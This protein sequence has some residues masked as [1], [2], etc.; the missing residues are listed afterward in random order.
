MRTNSQLVAMVSAV[1]IWSVCDVQVVGATAS[2]G[3]ATTP[4]WL[5][6]IIHLP[7]TES[8]QALWIGFRN[9]GK[10]PQGICLPV[11][12]DYSVSG[13]DGVDMGGS[14]WP[15]AGSPHSC[16]ADDG[17]HLVL[18]GETVFRLGLLPGARAGGP[19]SS[20][21]IAFTLQG[22][23]QELRAKTRH[24][25]AW[26]S[27]DAG[28]A[29]QV[30]AAGLVTGSLVPAGQWKASVIALF[31]GLRY[32]VG[33]RNDSTVPR[34]I[35]EPSVT[36]EKSSP[37]GKHLETWEVR[38]GA[39]ECPWGSEGEALLLLP[40][41]TSYSLVVL[42]IDVRRPFMVRVGAREINASQPYDESRVD[43]SVTVP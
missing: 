3:A 8:G 19:G 42:P 18:P 35:C 10:V 37:R 14:L 38:S 20:M 26:S 1:L 40:G 15:A 24:R 29:G 41:E 5:V 33:L 9:E 13:R 36:I 7:R 27:A 34:A 17:K 39:F 2:D 30:P 25:L 12:A 16:V 32:W 23:D 43:T 22:L 31:G 6:R 4:P 28:G 21:S 11:Q